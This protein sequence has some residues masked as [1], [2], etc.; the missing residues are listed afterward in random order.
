MSDSK[1]LLL[2]VSIG[3]ISATVG[4][5]TAP[6]LGQV[7]RSLDQLKKSVGKTEATQE[8]HTTEATEGKDD[9]P[10]P[11]QFRGCLRL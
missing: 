10:N 9:N 3:L 1:N 4:F 11:T 8:A 2:S 7:T 6:L 5:F